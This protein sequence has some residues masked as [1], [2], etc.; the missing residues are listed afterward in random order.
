VWPFMAS[1]SHSHRGRGARPP[2]SSR[3]GAQHGATRTP[4]G[5]LL[6]LWKDGKDCHSQ[7]VLPTYKEKEASKRSDEML[8]D[9]QC[10]LRGP[11]QQD[12]RSIALT[13]APA[14]NASSITSSGWIV[15]SGPL[16]M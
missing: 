8:R 15:D 16:R 1:H 3:G 6:A 14:S 7:L 13:M 5:Q 2:R 9:F 4:K 11:T 12:V 10:N